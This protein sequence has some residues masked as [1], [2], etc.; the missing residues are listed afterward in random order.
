M[1]YPEVFVGGSIESLPAAKAI[2]NN[3]QYAAR[4]TLW[5]QGI[6]ELTHTVLEDLLVAAERCDFAVFL[7]SPDDFTRSRGSEEPSP[8][9]NTIFEL[10]LF[11]GLLGRDRVFLVRP[12]DASVK[13]PTDL[14]GLTEANYLPPPDDRWESA[15]GPATNRIEVAIKKRRASIR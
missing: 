10:G 6:F 5:P 4:V 9:D 3:L 15:L 7:L 2:Q 12:R 1:V 13:L 8:R 11:I 14:L